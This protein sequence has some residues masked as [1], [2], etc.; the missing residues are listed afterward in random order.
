MKKHFI[1]VFTLFGLI[2]LGKLFIGS[3]INTENPQA[4]QKIFEDQY[5]V[6]ALNLPDDIEFCGERVPLEDR[7][8]K[9]RFDRELHVNAY[10]HSQTLL[11]MKRANRYF[12]TIRPIL[13]QH[14]I[15]DD[16]KY[17]P[18]I[19]SGFQDMVS[20][21]G[22]EGPWQFLA[23]TGRQYGLEIN[24]YVDERYQ[25]AKATEA[26]CKYLN[27]SYKRFGNWTLVAA[28]YNMGSAGLSRNM[29]NQQEN[30][31]YNLAL[32]NE[33]A[34]YVFRLLAIKEIM[35]NPQKYGFQYRKYHLYQQVPTY[36]LKVDSSIT[37]LVSFAKSQGINYKTL[38]E[39]NPWVK[40][41]KFVNT[42]GK[43][44]VFHI[45]KKKTEIGVIP[46][47]DLPVFEVPIQEGAL[48]DSMNRH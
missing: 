19:E 26:A 10:W 48:K 34:R 23:A 14:G 13:K 2:L 22:A 5:N 11:L 43:T 4:Y 3:T 18:L 38:K 6:F 46:D 44:Y 16:F 17:L 8:V 30:S 24:E 15:P 7:E 36:K 42:S 31:Y 37:N 40:G 28:S 25:L 9:E 32:N 21:A 12:P 29:S 39:H 41:S 27:E 35:K 33:T 1:S 20:P 45:P 47:E